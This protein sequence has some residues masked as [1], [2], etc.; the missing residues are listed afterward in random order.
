MYV[1]TFE[2][3]CKYIKTYKHI[4]LHVSIWI[5]KFMQTHTIACVRIFR[6]IQTH[7]IACLRIYKHA[8][9][10]MHMYFHISINIKGE[11]NCVS[12][13]LIFLFIFFFRPEKWF[14]VFSATDETRGW[15][16]AHSKAIKI[17]QI[18]FS[19]DFW[20]SQHRT[21]KTGKT[22]FS[23]YIWGTLNINWKSEANIIN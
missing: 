9:T 19:F 12:F 8:N 4:H 17:P 11:W 3:V 13:F 5:Y 23:Y 15:V 21:R 18:L 14:T 22:W 2:F 1:R 10:C 16:M 20:I 6:N 7:T